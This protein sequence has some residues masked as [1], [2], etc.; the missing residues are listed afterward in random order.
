MTPKHIFFYKYIFTHKKHWRPLFIP[1]LIPALA[2]IS[3]WEYSNVI[4][5][6]FFLPVIMIMIMTM[7]TVVIVII[8]SYINTNVLKT[9]HKC[10]SPPFILQ[11]ACIWANYLSDM[12]RKMI[13][14]S[15]A[16]YVVHWY[17]GLAMH[18]WPLP[19][20]YRSRT[21]CKM[22]AHVCSDLI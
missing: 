5:G 4:G 21:L 15:G 9:F 11:K 16:L 22:S 17:L 2:A 18:R 13:A 19:N 1:T 8:H 10:P 6:Y 20:H 3:S 14:C 12:K 7:M